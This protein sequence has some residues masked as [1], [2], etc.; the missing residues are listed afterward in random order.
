MKQETQI[1]FYYGLIAHQFRSK[2]KIKTSSFQKDR[3]WTCQQLKG[4]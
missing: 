4:N 2:L 3:T 1:N